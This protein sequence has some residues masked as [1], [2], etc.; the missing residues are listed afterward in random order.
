M[1]KNET[2]GRSQKGSLSALMTGSSSLD[3]S[4]IVT[5]EV[6]EYDSINMDELYVPEDIVPKE[7]MVGV[8][9]PVKIQ[10]KGI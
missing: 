7:T 1:K 3:A 6:M 5:V 10:A 9:A 4:E 2:S 8:S